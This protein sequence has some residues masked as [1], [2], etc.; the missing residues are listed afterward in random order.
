MTFTS[1][2]GHGNR[3]RPSAMSS[4]QCAIFVSLSTDIDA[5]QLIAAVFVDSGYR[6]NVVFDVLRSVYS[7]IMPTLR[8]D[9]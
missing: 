9:V 7:E 8:I 6:L 3:R 5:F 1:T 2:A 4:K